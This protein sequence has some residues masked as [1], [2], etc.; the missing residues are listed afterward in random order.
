MPETAT[1]AVVR[2]VLERATA[3]GLTPGA[4]LGWRRGEGPVRTVA[5][6]RAV[7]ASPTCRAR[8]ETVWDLA[9]LTKPLCVTT[10]SLRA[11]REGLLDLASP[12]AAVLPALEGSPLGTRSI[13]SLLHHTSGLPAWAPLYSL[14][15]GVPGRLLTVLA[16]LPL[17]AEEGRSVTYS[18]LGFILLGLALERCT[19]TS[20]RAL[21]AEWVL[22]P[23]RVSGELGFG[24]D[25]VRADRIAGGALTTRV[26]ASM[27]A[28]EGGDPA[29]VPPAGFGLCNDGNARFLGGVAGN[30][31]LFGTVGAVLRVAAEYLPG[32]GEILRAEEAEAAVTP[33]PGSARTRGLGW[34]LGSTPGCAAGP[35]MGEASYGH[36][37]F[38]GA[39]VWACPQRRVVICLLTN[40]L[41][42]SER[43][44]DLQPLRRKLHTAILS[45]GAVGTFR[46]PSGAQGRQPVD[47]EEGRQ[48]HRRPRSSHRR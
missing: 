10:L 39:S 31:G 23:L 1:E 33:G 34:T 42:P 16:R 6:G 25:W 20:L 12:V 32:G 28:A 3:A 45:T 41:H 5:L 40:R 30:A 2:S 18:C 37:G 29:L 9:S 17:Q 36:T 24:T 8:S 44:V 38:S 7:V 19:Q 26:E 46:A 4:V 14:T 11:S 22:R 13:H 15:G 21:F 35:A 43:V 27:T 48:G 47:R